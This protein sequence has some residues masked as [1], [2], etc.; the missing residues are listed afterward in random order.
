MHRVRRGRSTT[1]KRQWRQ[2]RHCIDTRCFSTVRHTSVRPLRQSDL[3]NR[4]RAT[5]RPARQPCASAL[6]RRTRRTPARPSR[7]DPSRNRLAGS[8]TDTAGGGEIAACPR[9]LNPL[10]ALIATLLISS[11]AAVVI[12]RKV[13]PCPERS[14]KL[15]VLPLLSVTV[16]VAVPFKP[17]RP[18][19]KSPQE[20]PGT[21]T[22]VLVRLPPALF[23][24]CCP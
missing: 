3:S 11:L 9:K 7:P 14:G 10:G 19:I 23:S 13:W 12:V 4:N 18:K 16:T 20:K 24:M 1:R 15:E 5:R 21:V 8:G 6:R 17:C 2:R 22:F